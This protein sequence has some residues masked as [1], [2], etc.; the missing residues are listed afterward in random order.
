MCAGSARG[1]ATAHRQ[2]D[3]LDDGLDLD[4]IRGAGRAATP[5]FALKTAFGFGGINAALE[6]RPTPD[7]F[8]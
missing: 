6:A 2:P 7:L 8:G 4:L 5:H 1:L 3:D